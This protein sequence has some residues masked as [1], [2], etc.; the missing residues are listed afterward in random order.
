MRE[1]H[2]SQRVWCPSIHWFLAFLLCSRIDRSGAYCFLPVGLF[3]CKNFCIG[4]SFWMVIDTVFIF[5]IYIPWGKTLSLVP[6]S[7]SSVKV[8]YQCLIFLKNGRCGGIC[9]S[10]HTSCLL[11]FSITNKAISMKLERNIHCQAEMCTSYF[12]G[13]WIYVPSIMALECIFM[14]LYRKIGGHIVLPL[15]VCPSVCLSAQT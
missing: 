15:S 1:V 11:Y 4:H 9:V 6:K 10:Q 14:P 8:K 7:R 12:C 2:R 3:V 13:S 5:H